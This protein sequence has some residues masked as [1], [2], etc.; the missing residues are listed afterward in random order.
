MTKF[1]NRL[2]QISSEFAL[3]NLP[4]KCAAISFNVFFSHRLCQQCRAALLGYIEDGYGNE[5]WS[6]ETQPQM[7]S[8]V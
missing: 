3:R 6:F 4:L 5:W 7:I 2:L 8:Q 1:H